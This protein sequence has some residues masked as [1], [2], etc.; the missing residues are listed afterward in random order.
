MTKFIKL[1]SALYLKLQK[2][3]NNACKNKS[4]KHYIKEIKHKRSKDKNEQKKTKN[5]RK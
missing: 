2:R 5:K 1:E 4:L 3:R